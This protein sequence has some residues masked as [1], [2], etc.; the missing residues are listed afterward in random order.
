MVIFHNIAVF[1]S[2]FVQINASLV[3]IRDFKNIT[4]ILTTTNLDASVTFIYLPALVFANIKLLWLQEH[5]SRQW[6]FGQCQRWDQPV[7]Q[8]RRDLWLH[9]MSGQLDQWLNTFFFC[10]FLPLWSF[11][12]DSVLFH[13]SLNCVLAF[14]IKQEILWVQGTLSMSWYHIIKRKLEPWRHKSCNSRI[15]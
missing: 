11:C 6:F 14:T 7:V 2:I 8:T 13:F 9:Q 3:R 1:Y 5:H 10:T 4:N 12:F 15:Y